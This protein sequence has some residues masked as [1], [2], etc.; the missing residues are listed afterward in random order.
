MYVSLSITN[1]SEYAYIKLLNYLKFNKE[2]TWDFR[3][4]Y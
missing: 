3:I 4:I 1:K 2:N